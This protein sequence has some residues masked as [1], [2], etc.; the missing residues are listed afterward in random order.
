MAAVR[1][2]ILPS[3][4]AC[5][6]PRQLVGLG[7]ADPLHH[8]FEQRPRRLR[9]FH[10]KAGRQTARA[11]MRAEGDLSQLS[12]RLSGQRRTQAHNLDIRRILTCGSGLWRTDRMHG[13]DLRIR[14]WGFES[15]GARP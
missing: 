12:H 14:S 2:R 10:G 15:L 5:D 3:L 7:V 6:R 4:R 9:V 13:I 1:R 8:R 11:R